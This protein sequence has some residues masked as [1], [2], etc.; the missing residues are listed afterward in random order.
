MANNKFQGPVKKGYNVEHFRKTGESIKESNSKK[1][2]KKKTKKFKIKNIQKFIKRAKAKGP[3]P[4]PATKTLSRFAQ[5]ST[6]LARE[7]EQRPEPV[8]DN[9]S[10]FFKEEFIKE[11][12]RVN[13]WLS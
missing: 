4:I 11:E 8:Q 3:T 10:Q 2:T 1:E 9:R 12:K 5:T 13:K 7:V 6:P